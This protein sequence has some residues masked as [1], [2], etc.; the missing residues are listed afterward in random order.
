MRMP[1]LALVLAAATLILVACDTFGGD[2]G[3]EP[4]PSPAPTS[5][6][7]N[8]DSASAE[9][10]LRL[11]V[12][13]RLSQGFVAKCDDAERPQDVGKQ[14]ASFR[15]ERGNLRAYE[16]G[17]TFAEYT[18]LIVLEQLAD[19]QWT[20]AHLESRD[21]SLPAAPG[22]PWPLAV[23]ERVV[24]AGTAPE[25]LRVREGPD[26]DAREIT[27]LPDGTQVTITDGPVEA[28]SLQW[29]QVDRLGWSA[30]NWLRYPDE[31]PAGG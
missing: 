27:C 15:G 30:S 22:I 6:D 31:V 7:A 28:D 2:S 12:E 1:A 13:R 10:A 19:G 23:G 26:Q 5:G 17:P 9:E 16:L 25:C 11:Y 3:G 24:V 21:P 29:W 18:R 14:C 8:G 20:I 4:S